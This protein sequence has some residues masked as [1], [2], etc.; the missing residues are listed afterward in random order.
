MTCSDFREYIS[1][2]LDEEL[3]ED[4]VSSLLNHIRKCP[5]CESIQLKGNNLMLKLKK[6][7][8]NILVPTL[9]VSFSKTV[10]GKIAKGNRT[11]VNTAVPFHQRH[12]LIRAFYGYSLRHPVMVGALVLLLGSIFA[13]GKFN[14][15]RG[16]NNVM[17]S[18]Y[19]LPTSHD[20][21]HM[22]KKFE[23]MESPFYR[24]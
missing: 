17:I 15:F 9:P 13:L 10:M 12:F 16:K 19:D 24:H 23:Y 7:R 14:I 22:E 3:N 1:S 18:V 5:L 21:S 11:R 4:E 8:D 20:Y 6:A 2:Y